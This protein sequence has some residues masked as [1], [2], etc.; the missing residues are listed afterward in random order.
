M[1]L[2]SPEKL[3]N[4][5]THAIASM[6]WHQAS[7][8]ESLIPKRHGRFGEQ[9]A[10]QTSPTQKE[11]EETRFLSLEE[12][13]EKEKKKEKRKRKREKEVNAGRCS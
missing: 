8:I 3:S 5:S 1:L 2:L 9:R 11:K 10:V 13:E 4:Q 12:E 7:W 6:Q